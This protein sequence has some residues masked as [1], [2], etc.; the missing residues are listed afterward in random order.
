MSIFAKKIINL[1]TVALSQIKHKLP[2]QKPL[3]PTGGVAMHDSSQ[4]P[5][6]VHPES[7]LTL[8]LNLVTTPQEPAYDAIPVNKT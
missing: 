7:A 6:V 8:N 1:N 2:T 5:E 4:D 3:L